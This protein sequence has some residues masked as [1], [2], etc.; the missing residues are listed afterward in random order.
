M[1]PEEIL[2]VPTPEKL[3]GIADP[4]NDEKL[5]VEER[6]LQRQSRASSIAATNGRPN[7]ALLREDS[8]DNP[9]RSPSARNDR[10]FQSGDKSEP[11]AAKSFNP[12]QSGTPNSP[13][14]AEPKAESVWTGPFNQPAPVVKPDLAQEARMESFRALMEPSAPPDKPATM[15]HL[16]P[17]PAPDPNLQPLPL[18]NRLGQSFT[19][20]Q[21]GISKPTGIARLPSITSPYAL[22]ATAR[23]EGQAQPPP[24]LSD[25][26][27]PF[28][29]PPRRTF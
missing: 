1:T 18:G 6:Y 22:P 9:F 23:P 3:L 15:A 16:A 10:M 28:G 8:P 24:W 12:F 2:G 21:S 7:A 26:P 11:G 20:L 29:N 13:F 17:L 25:S 4:K 14:G 27:Q 19:P 5:S